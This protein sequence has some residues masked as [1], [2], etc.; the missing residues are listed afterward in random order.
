MKLNFLSFAALVLATLCVVPFE[1]IHAEVIIPP[2][3]ATSSA[4]S[5]R[6]DTKI[7]A[8][9]EAAKK[10]AGQE[11]TRRI[12]SLTALSTRVG[13]MA[14]VS[15]EAKNKVSTMV[16][17]QVTELNQLK[18]KIDNDGDIESIKNDVASITK[19]YR[20]FMLVIPQ[21]RIQVA[22]DKIKMA[23]DTM[24]DLSVKLKTRIDAAQ[25]AGKDV[26]KLAATLVH[27]NTKIA[28]AVVQADAA[29]AQVLALI[30]DGGD[31]TQEQSNT[32]ALKDARAKLKVAQDNLAA[33]RTDAKT[34]IS[35]LKSFRLDTSASSTA[36]T[37]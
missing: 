13:E 14:R 22:S 5:A 7:T 37:Q 20:I 25:E 29:A 32:Q 12:E 30:P 16:Q 17:D 1:Y 2:A 15:V 23:S 35:A 19:S 34:I 36:A 18:G 6:V 21:G 27:M 24:N 9:I 10:R 11:I 3:G 4:R 33:A 31:K 28:D 26:T 8:R